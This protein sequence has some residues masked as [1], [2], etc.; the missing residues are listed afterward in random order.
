MIDNDHP[1]G[2]YLPEIAHPAYAFER[3]GY[4]LDA[5]SPKGGEAPLDQASVDAFKDDKECQAFL[6]SDKWQAWVKNTGKLSDVPAD[7]KGY[8]AVRGISGTAWQCVAHISAADLLPRRP[9]PLL[10]PARRRA[11]Q[12]PHQGLLRVGPSH[13][14]RVPRSRRRAYDS[15]SCVFRTSSPPA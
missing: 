1:T 2:Y 4:T 10:R 11:Q 9:R 5:V 3:A 12:G 13:D 8:D 15:V 7:G 14:G 6:K